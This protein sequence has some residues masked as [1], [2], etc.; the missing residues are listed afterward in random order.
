MAFTP[1]PFVGGDYGVV[2]PSF[3][4]GRANTNLSTLALAERLVERIG[5]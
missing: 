5:Q 2:R 1:R 4:S 3:R